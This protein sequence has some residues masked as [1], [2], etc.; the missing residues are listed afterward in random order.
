MSNSHR[1]TG[2]RESKSLMKKVRNL[3]SIYICIVVKCTFKHKDSF[4]FNPSIHMWNRFRFWPHG[5]AVVPYIPQPLLKRLQQ[6][7]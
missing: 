7:L 5:G 4:A 6:Q 2:Q 3:I 1:E